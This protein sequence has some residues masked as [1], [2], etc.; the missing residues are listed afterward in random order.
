[1]SQ[2]ETQTA[3]GPPRR[4]TGWEIPAVE[5]GDPPPGRDVLW[6]LLRRATI[7]GIGVSL[8]VHLILWLIAAV[9]TVNFKTPDAGGAPPGEVDFAVM[10]SVELA[11]IQE[12]EIQVETPPAPEDSASEES[13][14]ELMSDSVAMEAMTPELTELESALG[15]GEVSDST[16]FN[17]ASSGSGG[18]GAG[19]G[20]SFFGLEAQGRR[21]AYIVDR[22]A[23]MNGDTPSGRTRMELTQR[24]LDRSID[25]LLESAEFFVVFYSDR[26]TPLG[27]RRMWTDATARKKLWARRELYRVYP[28]GGTRPITGFDQVF[29]LRPPPDAIYFMTDGRFL[30]SVP[31][32]IARMNDREMIPIHCIMFGDFANST[33]REEVERMMRKIA[34]DSGGSF[35]RVRGTQP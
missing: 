19:G 29:A 22:S 23:S 1:M 26:A 15:S 3:P 11:T 21:F 5:G 2:L 9:V 4:D 18:A 10:T 7:A 25:A 6:R 12:S 34:S 28:D 24:E 31:E 8:L 33:V 20:A 17:A 14:M 13:L 30:H 27:S 16:S 35:A 32:D